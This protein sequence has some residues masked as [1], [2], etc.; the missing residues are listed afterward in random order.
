VIVAA[1]RYELD[2][3]ASQMGGIEMKKVNTG[4]ENMLAAYG[5]EIKD[6]LVLDTQNEDFPI[7]VTRNL[8][9][10][11]IREMQLIDYPYFVDIRADGMDKE[12]PVLAGLPAVTMQWASPITVTTPQAPAPAEKKEGEPE[13]NAPEKRE[14]AVLLKTSEKAWT[15]TETSV[16][17]DFDK[18]PEA[19]FG[20]TGE[21]KQY[22]LGVA[23]TGSFRSA[24]AGKKD[25]LGGDASGHVIERSP[26]SASLV[27]LGSS[28]FINDMVLSISR[29]TGSDRFTNNLQ[30]VQNLIDWGLEDVELLT[31]RSRGTYARTL[32]PPDARQ[33]GG[34]NGAYEVGNYAFVLL[35][36]AVIAG[37]T[38]GRRRRMTPIDLDP[39]SKR[40]APNLNQGATEV[41]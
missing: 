15:Q 32:L 6:A 29:Q 14:V 19:G 40:R 11:K 24:F 4:L 9:G 36:L 34:S 23:I 7:P 31:I 28:S 41:S 27:V 38:F 2:P 30:L 13:G 1:G 35:A 18:W 10:L 16:Q 37:L 3:H 12:N 8:G 22:D 25:P 39:Q 5:V 26:A 21:R 17:P 20:T 33:L